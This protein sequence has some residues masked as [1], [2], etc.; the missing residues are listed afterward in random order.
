M[1]DIRLQVDTEKYL[2]TLMEEHSDRLDMNSDPEDE[3]P[4]KWFDSRCNQLSKNRDMAV[5]QLEMAR[6]QGYLQITNFLQARKQYTESFEA[7]M[8][9]AAY[10]CNEAI[11][12]Q[13]KPAEAVS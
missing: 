1:S 2:A 8:I 11:D 10:K 13:R 12:R 3:D 7:R 9:D 4:Q 6:C 5:T